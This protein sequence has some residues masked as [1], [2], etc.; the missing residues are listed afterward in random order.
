MNQLLI[1]RVQRV[2]SALLKCGRAADQVVK[3]G[4][5][6]TWFE[7][8]AAATAQTSGSKPQ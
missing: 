2:I 8:K 1:L 5:P 3:N 7:A 4:N 6:P